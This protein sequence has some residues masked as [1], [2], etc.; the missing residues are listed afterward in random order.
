MLEERLALVVLL[1]QL[2]QFLDCPSYARWWRMTGGMRLVLPIMSPSKPNYPS[3]V[4]YLNSRGTGWHH[5]L[6]VPGI[7]P[8]LRLVARPDESRVKLTSRPMVLKKDVALDGKS[9][10]L[11]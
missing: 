5:C 10:Y 6:R 8:I 7:S 4:D 11:G 9:S 3:W 2:N 1:E